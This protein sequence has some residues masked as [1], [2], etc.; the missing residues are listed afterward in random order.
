MGGF[1]FILFL[2]YVAI[3]Y[4]I[5]RRY[6]A[7]RH[8]VPWGVK[9]DSGWI[10]PI[11][12]G[13]IEAMCVALTWPVASFQPTVESPQ[14]CTHQHHV[15]ARKQR[16]QKESSIH[17]QLRSK[18]KDQGLPTRGSNPLPSQSPNPLEPVRRAPSMS[19][20]HRTIAEALNMLGLEYVQ[21]EDRD[22]VYLIGRDGVLLMVG[23]KGMDGV[24]V[25]LVIVAIVLKNVECTK[26]LAV[27]LLKRNGRAT[28]ATWE[29]SDGSDGAVDVSFSYQLSAEQLD[30]GLVARMVNWVLEKSTEEIDALQAT[31][32]GERA[33]VVKEESPVVTEE[34][35]VAAEKPPELTIMPQGPVTFKG[36]YPGYE[37]AQ[38][39]AAF[40]S[41]PGQRRPSY[42]E[43]R[44]SFWMFDGGGCE[45]AIGC[46]AESD[47]TPVIFVTGFSEP[48][49]ESAERAMELLS[50]E[51]SA[52][53]QSAHSTARSS[54]DP[55]ARS[56]DDT[57]ARNEI[58]EAVA[59]GALRQLRPSEIKATP[60]SVRDEPAPAE[61]HDPGL[62]FDGL[63]RAQELSSR[64][65]LRFYA[66]GTVIQASTSGNPEQVARWF[67]KTHTEVPRG[68]YTVQGRSIEFSTVSSEGA[69][70][71]KGQ[72]VDDTI[73]LSSHSHINGHKAQSTFSFVRFEQDD[74]LR[75]SDQAV[76]KNY[77]REEEHMEASEKCP[78]CG[79]SGTCP[80]CNG[81]GTRRYGSHTLGC[82]DCDQLIAYPDY[83]NEGNGRCSTCHGTGRKPAYLNR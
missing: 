51:F 83:P 75:R 69:V 40:L 39:M 71:Y 9:T 62:R 34:Q 59:S 47:G 67:D 23:V 3:G 19:D 24:P 52:L 55:T 11:D 81:E 72:M 20:L 18:S 37:P 17:E 56:T 22:D 54:T 21:N 60:N 61:V 14:L 44:D 41:V 48:K 28:F 7:R 10:S 58:S 70:A 68:T 76:R 6:F 65:Y 26:E 1:L 5:A 50:G 2:V 25:G 32:G 30:V 31:Y 80:Y 43:A 36:R 8:G 74:P 27:D 35:P 16:E 78:S 53:Q 29:I 79:G 38:A 49:P 15:L 12:S 66:D 57:L 42:E 73:E 13:W 82:G 4:F 63:Y 46:Y 77:V 33:F 45:L 64:S